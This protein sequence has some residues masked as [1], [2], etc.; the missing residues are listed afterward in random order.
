MEGNVPQVSRCTV[1]YLKPLAILAAMMLDLMTFQ[2]NS[3]LYLSRYILTRLV[4]L[5]IYC[6]LAGS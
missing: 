5:N 6:I 2:L 3:T 4:I 1:L